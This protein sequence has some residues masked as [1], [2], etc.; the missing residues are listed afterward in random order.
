MLYYKYIRSLI[1]VCSSNTE[2][3]L[4]VGS[5]GIDVLSHCSN[6]PYK[7]SLDMRYP[8]CGEDIEAIRQDF[9]EYEPERVFDIVCCFQ[10]LEHIQDVEIFC[11]KLMRLSRNLVI[12]SVPYM[13]KEGRC[14]SHVQDPVDY[15]KL[16]GWFDCAPAFCN[17]V[18]ER[19][20]AVFLKDKNIRENLLEQNG[21]EFADFDQHFLT[22]SA[23]AELK[24]ECSEGERKIVLWGNG[25]CLAR[26]LSKVLERC[27]VKYVCDN[28]PNKWGDVVGGL[29]IKCIPPQAL[30]GL[31][32]IFVI[33]MI[34]DSGIAIQVANQLLNMGIREYE[35]LHNWL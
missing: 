17:I 1:A 28:D 2:A 26:N 18:E 5:G 29:D 24:F 35:Y 8:V 7:V 33:I 15:D 12:V 11:R 31:K 3:I 32:N 13:W 9:L 14:K 4:D 19:M 25:N 34:D 16:V 23:N 22:A 10:V 6:I 30:V 21:R 20:V 27:E